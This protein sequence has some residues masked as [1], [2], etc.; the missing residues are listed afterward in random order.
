MR[1]EIKPCQEYRQDSPW[2]RAGFIQKSLCRG[3]CGCMHCGA[4]TN[5]DTP[6]CQ[7]EDLPDYLLNEDGTGRY[8]AMRGA[9]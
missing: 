4:T 7:R 5:S 3:L 9:A 1:N 8:T 6:N 2:C